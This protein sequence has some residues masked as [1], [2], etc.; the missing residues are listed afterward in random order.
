MK[1]R[2]FPVN[3]S[4][5]IPSLGILTPCCRILYRN[6][7][8]VSVFFHTNSL[9]ANA[10]GLANTENAVYMLYFELRWFD[11]TR[12]RTFILNP[13]N[14]ANVPSRTPRMD[15]TSS[16]EVFD[17]ARKWMTE[18]K[19]I[20]DLLDNPNPWLPT[21]LIDLSG[22]RDKLGYNAWTAIPSKEGKGKIYTRTIV[23]T[24]DKVV[25][26]V[27]TKTGTQDNKSYYVT[28]S[29]KW[30]NVPGQNPLRLTTSNMQD[31]KNGLKLKD[32]PKTFRNAIE[33]AARLRNVRYIW[34]D[35][36]CIIQDSVEDWLMESSLMHRVYSLSF[37]NISATAAEHSHQGLHSKRNPSLLWETEINLNIEE[38]P[39][40]K[41][42]KD[43]PPGKRREYICRCIL[44]DASYC[45]NLVNRASVNR[46]GWV[47]QERL[48]APRILHFCKG[49]IAW[50][51]PEHT[52][53]EGLPSGVRHYQKRRGDIYFAEIPLKGLEPLVHGKALRENRLQSSYAPEPD[54]HLLSDPVSEK[55]MYALE[56]WNR[57]VG[58]YSKTELSFGKDKLPAL[59]GIANRMS[60]TIGCR[61]I[62]GLWDWHLASQLL[63]KV[64]P[65]Y[66][67][68]PSG[69]GRFVHS[70]KRPR[71]QVSGNRIYR[72]PSFSWASVDSH[73]SDSTTCGDVTDR[74]IMVTIESAV[75][76]QSTEQ[77]QD[78]FG[79]I[80]GGHIALWG[81]LFKINLFVKMEDR[82]FW[83]FDAGELG[84][85]DP[86][87]FKKLTEQD[88][89]STNL[90]CPYDD[91]NEHHILGSENI[92][93]LPVAQGNPLD[94]LEAKY[95]I[96]L[97]LQRDLCTPR[98]HGSGTFRRIG[99]TKLGPYMDNAGRLYVMENTRFPRNDED[100][101]E[102]ESGPQLLYII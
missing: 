91:D 75:I 93:F 33:F 71:D 32:I 50:E 11:L 55:R 39:R 31:F 13:I 96:G 8:I 21:R 5:H 46:R 80:S 90:D 22:L 9:F 99:L 15:D 87:V 28:L 14:E 88:R 62:A 98:I 12:R 20:K 59:S 37:L 54:P 43:V 38:V 97:L 65:V 4:L 74:D 18:C 86:K 85:H 30:G 27:D 48:L 78:K 58:M 66:Y 72:A 2:L 7:A 89:V 69:V 44:V 6:K 79:Q 77:R 60:E 94:S 29:H 102:L 49:Q 68:T 92:Y 61:Y 57:V 84:K 83:R 63:W 35:S 70:G 67:Q 81:F 10:Y 16:Q 41:A 73:D 25:K 34:I 42:V 64:Q 82:Y 45:E 53:A 24:D 52:A 23:N 51:C 19:C 47:L 40:S 36:L 95:V 56:I 1:V 17:L 101:A 3:L 76:A 100:R 26:L